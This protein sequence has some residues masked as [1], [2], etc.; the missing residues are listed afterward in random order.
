MCGDLIRENRY[1]A[2]AHYCPRYWKTFTRRKW[3]SSLFRVLNSFRPVAGLIAE[4]LKSKA[5]AKFAG[6]GF[7]HSQGW[8]DNTWG[9]YGWM[10]RELA[11]IWVDSF[12]TIP[13]S[14]CS[15]K[16]AS[17]TWPWATGLYVN[18]ACQILMMGGMNEERNL[19]VW[20]W[21]SEPTLSR[22]FCSVVFQTNGAL[23][24]SIGL[25]KILTRHP[26]PQAT[27]QC[28]GKGM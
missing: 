5:Q 8:L 17:Q 21:C 26:M 13:V 7:I 23:D 9:P 22:L 11:Y 27:H 19:I 28:T 16:S 1:V 12:K 10:L 20:T 14:K 4:K 3:F 2:L 25:L 15:Q 6:K 24:K 18:G